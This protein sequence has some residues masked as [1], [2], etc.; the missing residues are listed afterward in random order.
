MF[1]KIKKYNKVGEMIGMTS[2]AEK[3]YPDRH[4][5]HAR[6][7]AVGYFE[8]VIE[9]TEAL[10]RILASDKTRKNCTDAQL[11]CFYDNAV[12]KVEYQALT[13]DSCAS[14]CTD[15]MHHWFTD[16]RAFI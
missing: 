1:Y 9:E 7:K 3:D 10:Y 13:G 16:T 12:A 8:A 4:P 2:F 11:A 14:I 15:S 6:Y 5:S